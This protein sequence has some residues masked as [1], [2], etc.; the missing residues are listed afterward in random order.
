MGICGELNMAKQQNK[1]ELLLSSLIL[2]GLVYFVVAVCLKFSYL[3]FG[4][5]SLEEHET[6][7]AISFYVFLLT[8]IVVCLV[9]CKYWRSGVRSVVIGICLSTMGALVYLGFVG[10][11]Y[12]SNL[13]YD[14]PF[15]RDEWM[16]SKIRPYR[17][18]VPLVKNKELVGLTRGEVVEMLG[19]TTEET[20]SFRLYI[21]AEGDETWF[22]RIELDSDTVT[23]SEL[24]IPELGL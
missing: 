17:M 14:Y 11:I 19:A 24:Y 12:F 6:I 10:M 20:D 13:H 4:R 15:N 23:K 1:I 9:G 5:Q 3:D 16:Q 18:A 22:L 7:D 21:V 2:T 8:V